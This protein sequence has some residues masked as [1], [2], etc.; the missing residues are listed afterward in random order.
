MRTQRKDMFHW[1]RSMGYKLQEV[2]WLESP[3][4]NIDKPF[5]VFNDIKKVC[6]ENEIKAVAVWDFHRL[7]SNYYLLPVEMLI[8]KDFLVQYKVQLYVKQPNVIL[9]DENNNL[10]KNAS[11]T[12]AALSM[13]QAQ[14]LQ[15][16]TSKIHKQPN[17]N[18]TERQS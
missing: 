7:C 9:L 2:K 13:I 16:Y 8:I 4:S 18:R 12:F 1:L 6:L 11:V 3:C 5:M 15:T 14:V 17:D 10:S